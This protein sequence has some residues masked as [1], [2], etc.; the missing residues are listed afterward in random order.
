MNTTKTI[1]V[2][3]TLE[4]NGK[5]TYPKLPKGWSWIGSGKTASLNDKKLKYENEEQFEGPKESNKKMKE[6]I[7]K[8]F[9]KLKKNNIVKIYKIRNSYLP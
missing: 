8:V 7:D 1:F 9:T 4:S 5:W 2:F 6:I 3:Y